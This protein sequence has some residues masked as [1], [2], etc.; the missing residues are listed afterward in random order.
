M[1]STILG[2]PST[3]AAAI[4]AYLIQP[5]WKEGEFI[6]A[7]CS[8]KKSPRQKVFR[9]LPDLS[10]PLKLPCIFFRKKTHCCISGV[11]AAQP[12]SKHIAWHCS[13]ALCSIIMYTTT[14]SISTIYQSSSILTCFFLNYMAYWTLK[15]FVGIETMAFKPTLKK[16]KKKRFMALPLNTGYTDRNSVRGSR[17]RGSLRGL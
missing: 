15:Y 4:A 3:T 17:E 16:I 12:T 9:P 14:N 6:E 8:A 1:Y 5:Q 7:D 13:F 10:L 2:G 11:A